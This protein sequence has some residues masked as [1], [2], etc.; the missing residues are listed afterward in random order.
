ME[1]EGSAVNVQT[2]DQDPRLT[3]AWALHGLE[4]ALQNLDDGPAE[5]RVRRQFHQ[6]ILA[7]ER[8][9][10]LVADGLPEQSPASDKALVG[11]IPAE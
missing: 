9:S 7:V 6:L 2:T 4:R 10:L 3:L 1:L 5:R 11:D 8:H